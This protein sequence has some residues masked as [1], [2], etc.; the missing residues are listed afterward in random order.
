LPTVL[1]TGASRGLGL[2][3][4]RQYAADGN[5]VIA[6]CRTPETAKALG[7]I[8]Q[9][10]NT[11]QIEALDVLDSASINA[12]SAKLGTTAIDILINNAGVFSGA[13][14]KVT[15]VDND[16]SQTFGT[17]DAEAWDRVLHANTIAP[18]IV[19]Q[20]LL[21][22]IRLSSVRKVVMI[23]SGMGSIANANPGHIA[24]RSSKA[25]LNAAMRNIALGLKPEKITVISF[26]PG[27]VQTDMGGKQATLKPQTSIA[28]M[29]HVIDSLT[30]AQSG[31][32][33]AYNGET[34]PW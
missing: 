21:P 20:A 15:A 22:H 2:E 34:L 27:W 16:T 11:V 12:L 30:L 5:H 9:Q 26:H 3:F 33:V 8:A 23:S 18:I 31:Q 7:D 10:H 17:L 29:R 1:I 19:T 13:G 32:F 28:G 24:Y 4:V 14:P 25:A 6:C